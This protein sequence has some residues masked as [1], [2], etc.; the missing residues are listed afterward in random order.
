MVLKNCRRW[1]GLIGPLIVE[2]GAEG[3]KGTVNAC[4]FPGKT[5]L[6]VKNQ[7]KNHTQYI[8]VK[9]PFRSCVSPAFGGTP[10]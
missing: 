2:E 3:G 10:S 5:T 8:E 7:P 9:I 1:G 6:G 4:C